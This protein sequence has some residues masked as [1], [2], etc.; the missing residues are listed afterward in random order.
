MVFVTCPDCG[1]LDQ[2]LPLPTEPDE[3]WAK[4]YT[5]TECATLFDLDWG[6]SY[7]DGW[8]CEVVLSKAPQQPSTP[9]ADG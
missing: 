5:C 6:G 9:V 1:A 4:T 2:E 3:T 8:D 7:D